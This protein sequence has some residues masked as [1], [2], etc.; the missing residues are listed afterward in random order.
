VILLFAVVGAFSINNS[1][2]DVG[3]MLGFGLL[4]YCLE[5]SGFPIAPIILGMVLGGML[6]QNFVSSTIKAGGNPLA[7]VDRPV[8]GALAVLTVAIWTWPLGVRLLRRQ[9]LG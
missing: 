1:L 3:V 4:G 5:A 7:F 9:R 2:F 8:A 6:E